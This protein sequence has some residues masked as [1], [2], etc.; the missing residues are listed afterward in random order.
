MGT[1]PRG[2]GWICDDIPS[3]RVSSSSEPDPEISRAQDLRDGVMTVVQRV[4]V[5]LPSIARPRF[6]AAIHFRE[7]EIP[8]WMAL[9]EIKNLHVALEDAPR[10]SRR[11]PP[12]T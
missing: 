6:L 12:W 1:H 8:C 2:A 10:S 11:D 3:R 7:T 5:G 4:R 9:L